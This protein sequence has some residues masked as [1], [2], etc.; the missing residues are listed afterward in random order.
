[1]TAGEAANEQRISLHLVWI[2]FLSLQKLKKKKKNLIIQSGEGD[3]GDTT[4]EPLGLTLSRKSQMGL[5]S[6]Y[7]F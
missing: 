1:M 7:L 2:L 5:L 4:E 6:I 3:F